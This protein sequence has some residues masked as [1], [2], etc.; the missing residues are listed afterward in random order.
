MLVCF[1]PVFNH[2]C[3]LD[4]VLSLVQSPSQNPLFFISVIITLIPH[5]NFLHHHS[6]I[7]SAP[8]IFFFETE[9]NNAQKQSPNHIP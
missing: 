2:S 6:S 4:V 9:T 7:I 1:S 5:T 8:A 3:T